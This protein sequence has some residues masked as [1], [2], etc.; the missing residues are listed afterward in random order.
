LIQPRIHIRWYIL[1]DVIAAILSW[2][3]FYF[4]RKH[5]LGEPFIVGKNFY[6]GLI[7]MPFA[8]IS[9]FTLSGSY[10]GLYAKSRLFEF[11]H[12]AMVCIVG[13][14]LV[15]FF[16][17][18]YDAVNDN[19]IYYKEFLTLVAI[20]TFLT[21]FFRLLILN[22]TKKQLHTETVFFNTLLIGNTANANA[23]AKAIETNNEQTGYK[24]CGFINTNGNTTASEIKCLGSIEELNTII[25]NNNI[26]DVIISIEKKER[27]LLEKILQ[28]L[29]DKN[30]DIKIT[31]DRVDILSGAVQTNNVMGIP[32][33][34]LHKGFVPSWQQNI[35]RL[36]DVVISILAFIIL[37][38]LMLYTAIRVWLSSK[39]PLF[40]SQERIGYKGKPF[41]M[42]KFRSMYVDAEKDG[43]LLSNDNDTR[44]TTWGKIMRKWRLDELPQLINILKGEMTLVGPRPERQFYINQIVAQHP[45]YKYLFKAKPGLSSWGMVKFGYASTV[46]EIIERM[47]YDLIYIENA[48]LIIDFKIMLHTIK[49]MWGGKGK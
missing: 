31:P 38:P 9:L 12:T 33:I 45:E 8:W 6:V 34:D 39:G 46:E 5:I 4:F 44:I 18:L 19:S 49:I 37:L 21:Y 47:R 36:V 11:F 28:E 15:L 48:S 17:L 23:L 14:L 24:I 40:Y 32:L 42:Y 43:P 26:E 41:I 3:A 27:Q 10:T 16:F 22:K 2:V 7:A 29:G 25:K 20:Q 30:V 1:V 35:K 13:S